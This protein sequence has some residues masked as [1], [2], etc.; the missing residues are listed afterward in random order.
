[1]MTEKDSM[2][3]VCGIRPFMNVSIGMASG[4]FHGIHILTWIGC[5]KMA[6]IETQL[7][8]RSVFT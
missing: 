2:V 4:T 1:M 3:F 6:W 5:Y 7:L 8:S